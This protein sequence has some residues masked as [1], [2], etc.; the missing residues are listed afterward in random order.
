M[1]GPIPS[2]GKELGSSSVVRDDDHNSQAS[3][4]KLPTEIVHEIIKYL[5][6][7]SQAALVFTNKYLRRA[8][9][10]DPWRRLQ[11]REHSIARNNFIRGLERDLPDW[12]FCSS[13]EL[14]HPA[15]HFSSLWKQVESKKCVIVG[16]PRILS[17]FR[18]YSDH[19][20]MAF[21]R[22]LL[23]KPAG[24]CLE[25]LKQE[26]PPTFPESEQSE[27]VLKDT[28]TTIDVSS[29]LYD[30]NYSVQ[31]WFRHQRSRSYLS[32]HATFNFKFRKHK[33]NE[34]VLEFVELLQTDGFRICRHIVWGLHEVHRSEC[35][36][37][38]NFIWGRFAQPEC[39]QDRG[40]LRCPLCGTT[41][42]ITFVRDPA[43]LVKVM[44]IQI[45]KDWSVGRTD[46]DCVLSSPKI[47][48]GMESFERSLLP[49]DAQYEFPPNTDQSFDLPTGQQQLSQ[50]KRRSWRDHVKLARCW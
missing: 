17:H 23:G 37:V 44:W 28:I 5:S 43:L 31:D 47:L 16:A 4:D 25:I 7:E 35:V 39:Q 27:K 45:H 3:L 42:D 20:Q 29:H 33:T 1:K 13:C 9:G 8:I 34:E 12:K 46:L 38:N 50:P 2:N 6:V 32:W 40:S 11:T 26:H 10:S 41:F 22:Q 48:I 36:A 24:C 19:L 18:I 49:H 30:A 14:L 15:Q 21:E